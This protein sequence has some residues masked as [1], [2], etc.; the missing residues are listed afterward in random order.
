MPTDTQKTVKTSQETRLTPLYRV[1]LHNDDVNDMIHVIHALVET[2]HFPFKEA[3]KIMLEA[4]TSGDV[5][6]CK[7]EP[8]EPAELH[9]DKLQ[10][11]S[12]TAT[13]E[14]A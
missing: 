2:F 11:F 7:I 3:E 1:L 12:L 4:H 10:S 5:A 14:P 6:L 9:R 13:I 8:L